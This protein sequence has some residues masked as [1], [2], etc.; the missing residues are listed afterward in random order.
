MSL[1]FRGVQRT[2][3]RSA[4]GGSI[5]EGLWSRERKSYYSSREVLLLLRI[6]RAKETDIES[7]FVRLLI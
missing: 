6:V 2:D 3:Y 1:L 5:Y 4:I 7:S